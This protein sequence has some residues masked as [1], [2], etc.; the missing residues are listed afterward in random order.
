[1]DP[2]PAQLTF[3]FDC[4]QDAG[5]SSP[6]WPSPELVDSMGPC[7]AD[8]DAT[9]PPLDANASDG[10]HEGSAGEAQVD[11]GLGGAA[12]AG[13]S[14]GAAADADPDDVESAPPELRPAGACSHDGHGSSS[15]LAPLALF[16]AAGLVASR[17]RA[18]N[19]R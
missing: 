9:T 1:M 14:G 3:E 15:G 4:N 12:G 6:P 2:E 10:A 17:R 7:I 5:S 16:V 18:P 19:T 11:A 8:F 13:A